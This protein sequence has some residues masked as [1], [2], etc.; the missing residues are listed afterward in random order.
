MS[1]RKKCINWP[2][3]SDSMKHGVSQVELGEFFLGPSI[4]GSKFTETSLD[5]E[6]EGQNMDFTK[7]IRFSDCSL[8]CLNFCH[9]THFM[10]GFFT[11]RLISI[12]TYME[13]SP[14]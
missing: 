3:F 7:L 12:R 8:Y 5:R 14:S 2:L 13:L 10:N 11:V 1:E 6:P 4:F 9:K